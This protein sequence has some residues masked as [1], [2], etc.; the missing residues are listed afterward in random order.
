MIRV[1][2]FGDEIELIKIMYLIIKEVFVSYDEFLF[3]FGDVYIVN[4]DIFK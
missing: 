2:F 1:D 4:N 3:F